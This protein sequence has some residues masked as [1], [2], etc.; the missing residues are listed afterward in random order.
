MFK[1]RNLYSQQGGEREMERGLKE[2]I[3][4]VKKLPERCLDEAFDKLKEVKEKAEAEEESD[5]SCPKCGSREVVRNG[6]KCKKQAYRCMS[7]M[8][9]V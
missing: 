6:H 3:A 8:S 4:L 5:R 9:L 2:L 1:L 7:P